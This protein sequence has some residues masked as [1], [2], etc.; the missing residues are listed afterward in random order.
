MAYA[1]WSVVFGE[2]PSAA[3]WN[4]LGTNDAFFDSLI[5]SGTA[6]T[7]YT[8]TYTNLTTTSGTHSS[9]W[10]QFGKHV[11]VYLGF[12]FG[13]S[14]TLGSNASF[15][16]PTTSRSLSSETSLGTLSYYDSSGTAGYQLVVTWKSTSDAYIRV[17]ASSGSAILQQGTSATIPIAYGTNDIISGYFMYEAA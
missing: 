2:Q 11:H 7:A 3:K 14:S 4:I 13:A 15:T 6:W 16:L 5:G 10:Q 1:S 12:T 9:R 8:P 17:P